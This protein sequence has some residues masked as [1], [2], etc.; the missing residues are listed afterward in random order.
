MSQNAIAE[1]YM[2]TE[3]QTDWH[4]STSR[5]EVSRDTFH[6]I[7][8]TRNKT[9]EKAKYGDISQDV[10]CV[11]KRVVYRFIKRT[12]D[13]VF[14]ALVLVLLCW[15]YA[16]IAIAI[17]V[18]SKG[19]VIFKQERVGKDGKTF[20]M[21]KFRS[22]CDDAES[23]REELEEHNEKI[24][25]VFKMRN[26]PRVTKVGHFLRKMSLD[27]LPQFLNVLKGDMTIV[28]PRPALPREICSYTPYQKQRLMVKPGMTCYW[29]TRMDRDSITFDEWVN[30]DLLYIKNC[31]IWADVKLIVQ[32]IGVVLTAQGN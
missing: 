19:P 3:T 15:L 9:K 27:E 31:G 13:I 18:D 24:G 21:Y 5:A 4:S 29:Q 25:P 20:T 10:Q 1:E 16:I 22:M 32:T 6:V 2:P 17:K 14:S 12:F 26:D 30:L 23:M 7:D 8:F 28:G 11:Q